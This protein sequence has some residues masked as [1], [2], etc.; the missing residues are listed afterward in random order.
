MAPQEINARETIEQATE[1]LETET[2]ISPAF[3]SMFKLL[4]YERLERFEQW[5][6][7]ISNRLL[8]Y[9]YSHPLRGTVAMKSGGVIPYFKDILCHDH[10][11][12]YYAYSCIHS[13]CNA[14]HLR[15]LERAVEHDNQEW[16]RKMKD[17]PVQMNTAVDGAG[18][19][20]SREESE[21]HRRR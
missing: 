14:H 8:T 5:L 18:G 2:G 6:H 21:N 12:P 10:W 17:L 20:L 1:R 15:E 3:R 13:L 7:C 11:K 4:P 16:A 9:L 19:K